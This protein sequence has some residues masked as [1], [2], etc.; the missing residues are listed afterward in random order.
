MEQTAPGKGRID[1][2][3]LALVW[4]LLAAAFAVR[5][6]TTMQDGPLLADTD[7]AM[8][9]VVVRD[10]LGGQGWYDNIQHRMNTPLGAEMHWSRLADLPLAGLVLLLRPFLGTLAETVAAFALPLL[11]LL[12]LLWLSARIAIAL[13]GR[14]AV[15]PALILPALS[16]SVLGEFTPGRIDHHSMQILLLLTMLWCAIEALSRP[17]FALGAGLAAATATAIGI[18]GL[19]GVAAVVLAFGLMWVVRPERA[20]ALRLFGGGLGGGTVLHALVALPP[21]RWLVPACDALSLTYV[22]AAGAVGAAFVILSLVPLRSAW[23]RLGLGVVAGGAVLA[24]LAFGFPECLRGPYAGLDPW[25]LANWIDRVT[26]AEPLWERLMDDPVYPLAVAV[27]CAVAVLALVV[28]LARGPAEGKDAWLVLAVF[29]G[30]AVATMLIQIRASRMATLVAVPACAALIVMA[31]HWYLEHKSPVGLAALALG[32]VASAGVIV[33]ALAV[34]A[35]SALPAPPGRAAEGERTS[36]RACLAPAAFEALA[37]L[38]PA[39]AMAPI[40]LGSHLLAFTPHEVAGAPYHRNEDG[41]RD[42]F[43]FFNGPIEAARAILE[44]RGISLVVVCPS[45]PEM[46]GLADAAPD[47]FVRLHAA[48]ALPGWL[49]RLERPG[50]PLELYA[51]AAR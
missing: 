26:E 43:D 6:I 2:R 44:R 47:S 4:V 39:R 32:W 51:V 9:L 37:A 15:L 21:D 17:R 36:V 10:L 11:L 27:P 14:E 18:E 40:D 46:R 33:A 41:V 22:V 31:R 20:D 50:S 49:T 5:G 8:R 23:A 25:L 38:P 1:W 24:G 29:L 16:L 13:A 30:L 35:T 34:G 42:T 12:P 45:M 28:R 3:L 7:D 48:G 19:P